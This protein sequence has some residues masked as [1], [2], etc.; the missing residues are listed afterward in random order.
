MGQKI[1]NDNLVI[2]YKFSI[3]PPIFWVVEKYREVAV[4]MEEVTLESAW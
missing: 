3:L 4:Y 2:S 1:K